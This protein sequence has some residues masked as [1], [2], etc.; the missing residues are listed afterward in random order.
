MCAMPLTWRR[1]PCARD[2]TN[3]FLRRD[4][5]RSGSLGRAWA[6]LVI[7][8]SFVVELEPTAELANLML[9]I[10]RN[11]QVTGQDA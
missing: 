5:K 2:G 1:G 11:G 8:V 9:H 10:D 7:G 3:Q 6:P 4:P